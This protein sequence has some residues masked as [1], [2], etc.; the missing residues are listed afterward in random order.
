MLF[1]SLQ[2]YAFSLFA[3]KCF[4]WM[5]LW[6]HNGFVSSRSNPSNGHFLTYWTKSTL[7]SSDIL[8]H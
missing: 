8:I 3:N 4:S 2:K 1:W 6:L 5:Y 7:A